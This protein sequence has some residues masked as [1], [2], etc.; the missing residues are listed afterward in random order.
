MITWF[1]KLPWVEKFGWSVLGLVL[2]GLLI[3]I[4]F[5]GLRRIPAWRNLQNLEAEKRVGLKIEII[6]T[7][8]SIFGGL[9]FLATLYLTWASLEATKEK[10]QA[11]LK[12][13]QDKQITELY[14][15]AIEQLGRPVLEVRL[16]SIYALER[17]AH[18]SEKD[19]WPIMEVLTA[20]VRENGPW[21]PEDPVAA[22]KRRPWTGQ[23]KKGIGAQ[24]T[25]KAK[26]WG[27]F[28]HKPDIDIQSILTVIGRRSRSF[29]KMETQP[30][31][32]RETDLRDAN[33]F[34]THLEG[35]NLFNA[36]L[37]GAFLFKAHLEG[38]NLW[39]ANLGEANLFEAH[40]GGVYL[41]EAHLEGA[42]LSEAKGLT[43]EQIDMAYCDDET[44]LPPGFN[45]SGKK[46]PR[47]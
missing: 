9:F 43:Q 37:E 30:L 4:F 46:K 11:D 38:A 20:Y 35:A 13:A 15:K 8:A 16:G 3:T 19:H 47:P 36:Q 28:R 29:A 10:N 14:V 17:I 40:M 5:F 24:E 45:C 39:R 1:A 22:Q 21:P 6:K 32:L 18:D 31:N 27:E 23:G 7:A 2:L 34:E 33:L 44:K 42:N 26:A 41:G 25:D 12:M